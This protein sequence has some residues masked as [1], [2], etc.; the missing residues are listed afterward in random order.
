M[1]SPSCPAPAKH[2]QWLHLHVTLG[3][4]GLADR[5]G[6]RA[7][8]PCAEWQWEDDSSQWSVPLLV[9]GVGGCDG[10]G[11]AGTMSKKEIEEAYAISRRIEGEERAL[12]AAIS[13]TTS[14][15]QEIDEQWNLYD[16]CARLRACCV[17][18][19]S[20]TLHARNVV[21]VTRTSAVLTRT[22]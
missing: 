4:V 9:R 8:A 13:V 3:G 6:A 1:D 20:G 14:T 10:C 16:G 19:L 15:Q 22:I 18:A 2:A 11:R 21:A 7:D 12:E 17:A 5:V